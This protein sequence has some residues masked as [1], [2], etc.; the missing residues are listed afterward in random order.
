MINTIKK[1][2]VT[3]VRRIVVAFFCSLAL[4]GFLSYFLFPVSETTKNP[5]VTIRDWMQV[6]PTKWGFYLL[7]A[8]LIGLYLGWR[9]CLYNRLHNEFKTMEENEKGKGSK[10]TP[11]DWWVVQK[12]QRRAFALHLRA[13]MILAGL[14]ALLV[15]GIYLILFILPQVEPLDRVLAREIRSQER[16]TIFKKDYGTT[17][18][19]MGD[20]RYWFKVAEMSQDCRQQRE[21]SPNQKEMQAKRVPSNQLKVCKIQNNKHAILAFGFRIVLVTRDGGKTWSSSTPLE[22]KTDERIATAAFDA[23]GPQGVVVGDEGSVFVTQDGGQTWKPSTPLELKKYESIDTGAFDVDGQQGVAV[24]DEGSVFVTLDGGQTW[25]PS[26]PLELKKYESIDTG[27]FD[28]DSQQGV[29]VGD[30]GSVFVTQDGGETWNRSQGFTLQKNESI[31]TAA[32]DADGPQGVVVGD[33]GS[34]FVTQDSGQA[35]SI[36]KGLELKENESIATAAFDADDHQGVVVSD[37]GSVFVTQNGG[38]T[39][40]LSKSLELKK[41][42]WITTAAFD[43]DAQQGVVVGDADSVF[44]TQDGGE[45]WSPP[46]SLELKPDEWITAAVFDADAQQGVVVGDQGSAFVTRD[47]GQ[48][49]ISTERAY[50]GTYFMDVVSTSPNGR[51]YMAVDKAGKVH[52][53]KAYP[54]MAKWDDLSLKEIQ[55]YINATP[56]FVRESKIGKQ[57]AKFLESPIGHDDDG[58]D[59]AQSVTGNK[60]DFLGDFLGRGRVVTLVFLSVLVGFLIRLYQYNMRLSAFWESRAVAVLLAQ[61]FAH[62]N[63]ESFDDLMNALAP[64]AYDFKSSSR[65]MF[66]PLF[67]RL[68]GRREP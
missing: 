16:E 47:S 25:K 46:K 44:V 12:L 19:L 6:T 5:S 33:E 55:N 59:G 35:W 27:A 3:D 26:T 2:M 8:G 45:T 31:A 11:R 53:L 29:V 57:I 50:S 60:E 67:S 58:D 1:F 30:A 28:V 10:L 40:S 15:G 42:E 41:D 7:I 61:S 62:R 24:G 9:W 51:K 22:L 18:R 65:S 39:W 48:T 36:S 63:A 13:D 14:I 49:W 4:G 37:Q 38:E 32:F 20:G 64:D 54:K 66:E 68:K 43:A 17:L 34:V 23:D 21:L 56:K 52:L